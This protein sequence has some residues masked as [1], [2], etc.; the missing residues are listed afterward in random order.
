[1]PQLDEE[2]VEDKNQLTQRLEALVKAQGVVQGPRITPGSLEDNTF[3]PAL[4]LHFN[5][6]WHIDIGWAVFCMDK[7]HFIPFEEPEKQ[8]EAIRKGLIQ[9]EDANQVKVSDSVTDVCKL[10]EVSVISQI[11]VRV[12]SMETHIVIQTFIQTLDEKTNDFFVRLLQKPQ[13]KERMIRLMQD[14][15]FPLTMEIEKGPSGVSSLAEKN[16]ELAGL[17]RR[18]GRFRHDLNMSEK[19]ALKAA[20]KEWQE[21]NDPDA[22]AKSSNKA[23]AGGPAARL[24]PGMEVEIHSLKSK[25]KEFLN[26]QKGVLISE[27][28]NGRWDVNI[29]RDPTTYRILPQNLTPIAVSDET[30]APATRSRKSNK[31]A[32]PKVSGIVN[33]MVDKTYNRVGVCL[34][35]MLPALNERLLKFGVT[36]DG[37]K[38]HQIVMC[39]TD[40]EEEILDVIFNPWFTEVNGQT[41]GNH[42][43]IMEDLA[44]KHLVLDGVGMNGSL[45]KMTTA[46]CQGC[47]SQAGKE[48]T[49]VTD[50]FDQQRGCCYVSFN[51]NH[52][53]MQK[54]RDYFKQHL[55]WQQTNRD[56]QQ[57]RSQEALAKQGASSAPA[58]TDT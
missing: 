14:I 58:A 17:M 12:I 9:L 54:I 57:R 36:T 10:F 21:K 11:N 52:D 56:K 6:M 38:L 26:G 22:G 7:F 29:S 25:D 15:K 18:T 37:K 41:T 33:P 40:S 51:L 2:V 44:A 3:T 20:I 31:A 27:N 8:M 46:R 28:D 55:E 32:V 34:Q 43:I 4:R 47:K 5:S 53:K 30:A 16:K 45:M 50:Q 23:P 49:D 35:K 13:H 24:R 1:L 39:D 48:I 42:F 19:D